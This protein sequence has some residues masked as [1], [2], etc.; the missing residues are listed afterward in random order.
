MRWRKMVFELPLDVF[1][2]FSQKENQRLGNAPKSL[3]INVDQ[4][5][6]EPGTFRL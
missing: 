3:I 2:L 5:G 6:L 4:P 1:A